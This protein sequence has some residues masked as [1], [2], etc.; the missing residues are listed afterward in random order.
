MVLIFTLDDDNGT[1]LAG[2]RQ[3]RD[4]VVGDKIIA[5]AGESLHILH[6]STSFFK[7]NDMTNVSCTICSDMWSIPKDAVFFVEEVVPTEIMEAAEK[8][9]VF[10]WNRRYPSMVKDRVNLD[11][12]TKSII[13]EFPGYS[14][15]KI[16]LE[17]Y[18]K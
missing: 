3:S 9:Y 16:T 18:E 7:N 5:L 1:Q 15:E 13:E 2:K 6:S 17:V 4:R 8:I 11:G 12:Y 10:R 14:H